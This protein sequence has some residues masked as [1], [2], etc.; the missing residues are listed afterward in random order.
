[1]DDQFFNKG[2]AAR[3]ATL[4]AEYVEKTLGGANALTRPF[5]EA[6]T[7]WCW[8]FGWGDSALDAKTRSLLNL[9]MLGALG[10]N[11]EWRLHCQGAI[12]NGATMEEIRA[13]IHTVAIYAGVPAALE[14]FQAAQEILKE[15]NLL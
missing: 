4:G 2:L 9:A 10:K 5:Q 6:M 14:C 13:V 8:G 1:M 3:K 15:N 11:R 7:A 12:R